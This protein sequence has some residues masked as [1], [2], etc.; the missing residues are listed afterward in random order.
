MNKN[1]GGANVSVP[2]LGLSSRRHVYLM[3][4]AVTRF[5]LAAG[6]I[7]P[8]MVNVIPGLGVHPAFSPCCKWSSQRARSL[9]I[10]SCVQPIEDKALGC[11]RALGA[12][13][14][15]VLGSS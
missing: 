4:L 7:A 9:E 2:N 3:T 8:I 13:M 15:A 6:L 5:D 14:Q 1:G 12:R 10:S 11:M